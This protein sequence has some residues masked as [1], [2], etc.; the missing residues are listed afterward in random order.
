MGPGLGFVYWPDADNTV[1]VG[2]KISEEVKSIKK[3]IS[4]IHCIG[5]SLGSHICGFASSNYNKFDRISALDP[6]GPHFYQKP[7]SQRL[8]PTD[9]KFV[10]AYHTN[11]GTGIK[12]GCFGYLGNI[13]FFLI[14]NL[15]TI[16]N[17]LK[18]LKIGEKDMQIL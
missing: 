8:D 5:H 16:N 7:I 4:S 1:K 14:L 6:A 18:L 12:S 10:D 17:F 15:Y 13:G 3:T 11:D 9:A 2:D